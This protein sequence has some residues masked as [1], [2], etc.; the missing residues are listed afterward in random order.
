MAMKG[1][2]LILYDSNLF[3]SLLYDLQTHDDMIIWLRPVQGQST[4]PSIQ[5]LIRCHTNTSLV[6]IIISELH[7]WKV[8]ILVTT[9]IKNTIVE[10]VL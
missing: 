8:V 3:S 5:G 10:H 7:Q 2:K 9:K 1:L 6:T 4:K